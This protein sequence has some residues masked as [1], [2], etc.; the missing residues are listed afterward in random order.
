MQI[1]EPDRA[2]EPIIVLY[3]VQYNMKIFKKKV[4]FKNTKNFKLEKSIKWSRW[5]PMYH[6]GPSP[7]KPI[8]V[9]K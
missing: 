8:L 9:Q 7:M 2:L 4:L 6:S 1:W 3:E 5:V